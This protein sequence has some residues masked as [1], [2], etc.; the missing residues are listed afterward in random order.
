MA[1]IEICYKIVERDNNAVKTLFHGFNKSR[2]LPTGEWLTAE[3]KTVQDGSNGTPYIS[4]WHVLKSKQE[5]YDYLEKF[6][7]KDNKEIIACRVRGLRPKE[8]SYDNVF[9][10]DE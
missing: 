9:L 6:Q 3:K 10:A 2:T 7:H 5:C 4:G 8:H 1:D